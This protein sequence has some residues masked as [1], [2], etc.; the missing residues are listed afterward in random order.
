MSPAPKMTIRAI[1]LLSH[2]HGELEE[3]VVVQQGDVSREAG[4]AIVEVKQRIGVKEVRPLARRVRVRRQ[5]VEGKAGA[6]QPVERIQRFLDVRTPS[7]VVDS[8]PHVEY[9]AR[10]GIGRRLKVGG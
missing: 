5:H 3:R 7:Y 10:D 4:P 6:A 8:R 2:E 9:A 1:S